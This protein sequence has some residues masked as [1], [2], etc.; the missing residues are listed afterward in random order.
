MATSKTKTTKAVKAP[1]KATTKAVKA[2]AKA[3]K[4]TFDVRTI[5]GIEGALD[6]A[7][8]AEAQAKGKAG[9]KPRAKQL[10]V[11]GTERVQDPEIRACAEDLAEASETLSEAHTEREQAAERLI[12]MMTKKALKSYVD[13]KLKLRVDLVTGRE[14]VKLKRLEEKGSSAA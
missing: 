6:K 13:E 2:P 9:K 14:K 1:A 8:Q 7:V 4:A 11:P 3:T 10:E 5:E 12:A